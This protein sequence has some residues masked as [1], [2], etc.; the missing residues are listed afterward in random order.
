MFISGNLMFYGGVLFMISA[1]FASITSGDSVNL[2]LMHSRMF[3]LV[4]GGI[5]MICGAIF[6]CHGKKRPAP[7]E[8]PTAYAIPYKEDKPAPAFLDKLR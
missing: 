7:P 6:M 3:T 5:F 8:L 4:Q 1:A 2:G